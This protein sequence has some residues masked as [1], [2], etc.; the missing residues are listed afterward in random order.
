MRRQAADGDWP[1]EGIT[2]VC[3]RGLVVAH[4]LTIPSRLYTNL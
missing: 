1:Q 3:S 2:G 4:L